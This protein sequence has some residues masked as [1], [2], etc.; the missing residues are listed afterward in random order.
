VVAAELP[1]LL[2]KR[3]SI[4]PCGPEATAG[5]A[6]ALLDFSPTFPDTSRSFTL[7]VDPMDIDRALDGIETRVS[8]AVASY[9]RTRARQA[10]KQREAGRRDQGARAAVTGGAQM[11]G[12]MDLLS[13]LIR[14]AGVKNEHI[15]H[16]RGLEIP[17]FYRPTKEWD[18]LVVRED[19]LLVLIEC[20]SQ[21]GSFG[22]NF[23]NR[24]EEAMGSALDV[25]T[26]HRE[27][28]YGATSRP[29]LGYVFM[30]QDCPQSRS[31]VRVK[32]PHFPV[33]PEF[34]DASYA[35][36][37]EIFCR[38]LVIERQYDAAAFLISQETTGKRGGYVEPA[39]DLGFNI[40]ARSLVAHLAAFAK[41][42]T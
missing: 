40:F 7:E 30:L 31:P 4:T 10:R 12:F 13:E 1:A 11:Q 8:R 23:N 6:G 25:W 26:A 16:K 15:H 2:I 33:F 42:M 22:N 14:T 3:A 38:K 39:E 17:G 28:A 24:T 5:S 18:L 27:R 34:A 9:W 41:G 19:Q 37:Y 32:E 35:R 29:W 21:V 36:R 20:K